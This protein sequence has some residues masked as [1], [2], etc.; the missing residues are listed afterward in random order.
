MR[1]FLPIK[2]VCSNGG[3]ANEPLA[4]PVQALQYSVLSLLLLRKVIHHPV[5][6]LQPNQTGDVVEFLSDVWRLKGIQLGGTKQS[7]IESCWFAYCPSTGSRQKET[8][9]KR[10]DLQHSS[11]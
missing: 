9:P 10:A 1:T 5:V 11:Y 7:D 4:T 8:S 3:L 2:T 6:Y